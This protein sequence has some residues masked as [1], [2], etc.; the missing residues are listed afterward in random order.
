MDLKHPL[1]LIGALAS[2]S[3]Y[4]WSIG[5]TVMF[6][7]V[8]AEARIQEDLLPEVQGAGVRRRGNQQDG[9]P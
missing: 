7:R 5:L 2:T 6:M 3:P 9:A 4:S 8:L 1:L